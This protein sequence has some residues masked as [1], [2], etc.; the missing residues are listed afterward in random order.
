MIADRSLLWRL[1][2][3]AAALA[4]SACQAPPPASETPLT[5]SL[6]VMAM[7]TVQ[8]AT[9]TP[10]LQPLSL[11]ATVAPE[12]TV[13]VNTATPQ[14][15]ITDGGALP[16][17]ARMRIGIGMI[18]AAALSPDGTMLAVGSDTGVY[19]YAV[20]SFVHIWRRYTE[21]PVESVDWSPDGRS[22]LTGSNE[23]G[24]PVLWNAASG[25]KL[26]E[27]DGWLSP[28]WSPDGRQ[29]AVAAKPASLFDGQTHSVFVHDAATGAITRTLDIPSDIVEYKVV[30]TLAWSPDGRTIAGGTLGSICVWSASTGQPIYDPLTNISFGDDGEIGFRPDG[31]LLNIARGLSALPSHRSVPLWKVETGEPG[32]EID[33]GSNELPEEIRWSPDGSYIAMPGT[34]GLSVAD[35]HSGKIVYT[36]PG[37]IFHAAW[38][39]DGRNLALVTSD[40]I[41]ILDA[42]SRQ[43]IR[44]MPG[45]AYQNVYDDGRAAGAVWLPDG[46]RLITHSRKSIILWDTQTGTALQGFSTSTYLSTVAWLPDGITLA[47]SSL[48]GYQLWNA[49][50]EAMLS[51]PSADFDPGALLFS[52]E[53][54]GTMLSP[55]ENL[56]VEEEPLGDGGCGDGPFGGGCFRGS[57]HIT[58]KEVA[59]GKVVFGADYAGAVGSLAWSPDATLLAIG[60]A[61]IEG[62]EVGATGTRGS[63]VIV[64][65]VAA[66]QQI[67]TLSGHSGNVLGLAWSP[68]GY[69]LAS[70]STDATV[71]VWNVPH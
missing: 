14:P 20:D 51:A 43:P 9:S 48:D 58:I 12:P 34:K 16:E 52:T 19:V 46:V 2:G 31:T 17:G 32:V 44:E 1:L 68:N 30:V 13:I 55:H 33:L 61:R 40:K 5:P 53:A 54:S 45:E 28:V 39:P 23:D 25:Q 41:V 27:F 22:L 62:G 8:T 29:V 63:D 66:G 11:V 6:T 15:F 57:H 67:A 50:S 60:L 4:L 10:T 56:I 37:V 24:N 65:D 38:S 21:Y 42:A 26:Q 69:W 70:T 49:D 7:P 35:A 3:L 64:I 18:N 36:Y 71:I 59:T 47:L